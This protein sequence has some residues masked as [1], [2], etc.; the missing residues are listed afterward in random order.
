MARNNSTPLTFFLSCTIRELSA[1][2]RTNN[3]IVQEN[4]K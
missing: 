2:I 1:W 4:R 3:E